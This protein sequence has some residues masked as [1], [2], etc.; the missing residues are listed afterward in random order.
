MVLFSR[1]A[2][3]GVFHPHYLQGGKKME[4]AIQATV[5]GYSSPMT[6]EEEVE[7][8][9][10]RGKDISEEKF[11]EL[12]KDELSQCYSY[13]T[14]DMVLNKANHESEIEDWELDNFRIINF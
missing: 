5:I 7:G 8:L 6:M 4:T 10:Y 14:E 11:D 12:V 13:F 2:L 1:I 3:T 9:F